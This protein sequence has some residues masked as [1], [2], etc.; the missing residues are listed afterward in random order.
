[1]ENKPLYLAL[2][3]CSEG[4][5]CHGQYLLIACLPY[6]T[7]SAAA[8]SQSSDPL[9][10]PNPAAINMPTMLDTSSVP[11][12]V[13]LVRYKLDNATCFQVLVEWLRKQRDTAY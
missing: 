1:M 9:P 11:I 8:I 13:K 7:M 2:Y 3:K 10:D 12:M 5:F 6:A 4:G